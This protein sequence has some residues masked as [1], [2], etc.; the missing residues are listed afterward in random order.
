MLSGRLGYS[1]GLY[2][3]RHIYGHLLQELGTQGAEA[4]AFD[5][6]LAEMRPDHT[7]VELPDGTRM[8]LRDGL[9]PHLIFGLPVDWPRS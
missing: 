3:P 4:V 1:A 2:W 7:P 9:P 5:V 6:L 8:E